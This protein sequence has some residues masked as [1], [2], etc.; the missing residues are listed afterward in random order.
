MS[1]LV[2]IYGGSGF[3]GRYIARRLAREGWR[4]RIAC[5][6]PNEALFTKP[7]GAVGQVEPVLCNIRD[8]ASV[9][10]AMQGADAVVNC[11]GI[12]AES[13]KNRFD[14]VHVEGARLIARTAAELGVARLVHVSA[15][16]ADAELSSAYARSKAAGEAAVR[17][18]FPSAVILRP[19]VMFG[20]E[21]HFF[22][23]LAA[24]SLIGPVM[25]VVAPKTRLQPVYVDDVARVAVL[26]LDGG[27]E[28]TCELGG[29]DVDTMRGLATR[30]LGVI[31]RRR[32]VIGLPGFVAAIIATLGD[33]VQGATFGLVSNK[34]LTRDQLRGLKVD[35]IVSP[36]AQ[37]FD[38]LG[39][40]PTA[41][42][43]VLPDYLWRFRKS[44]QYE[45]IKA[46]AK[47]LRKTL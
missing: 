25:A 33:T 10:A 17:G 39:I 27:V 40:V 5:R 31:E 46:S 13:G 19:S 26:A 8:A 23:K 45:A 16:G 37:S 20:T 28:G 9:R 47:N 14:A 42:G 7:Y 12:L 36:D 3:L 29:P 18:A 43:A 35:N 4:I 32:G 2:T 1:K 41:M 44:G 30:M 24:L 21:D 11:V 34:L 38:T 6:R 15:L 22:N